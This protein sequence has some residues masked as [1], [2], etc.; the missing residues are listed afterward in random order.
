MRRKPRIWIF[1]FFGKNVK[2]NFFS[3]LYLHV[4]VSHPDPVD[5]P[6]VVLHAVRH[7]QHVELAHDHGA[8]PA[9]KGKKN[10]AFQIVI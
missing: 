1:F 7:R 8:A 3:P 2:N 5:V 9:G 4:P 10:E 6:G